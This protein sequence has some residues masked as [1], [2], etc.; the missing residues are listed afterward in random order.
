M[1]KLRASSERQGFRLAHFSIQRDHLHMIVE[2]EDRRALTAGM[3]GLLVRVAR[4]LNQSWRRTGKVFKRFH[5]HLL[6]GPREVRNALRL[7]PAQRP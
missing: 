2:A 4:A 5:E 7:R 3:K 6:R 1:K